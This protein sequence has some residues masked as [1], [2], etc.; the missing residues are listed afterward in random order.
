MITTKTITI[1]LTIK[2][3]RKI[4]EDRKNNNYISNHTN[5]Q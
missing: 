2:I 1:T 3:D 4:E 5:R